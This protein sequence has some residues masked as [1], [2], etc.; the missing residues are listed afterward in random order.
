MKHKQ[1]NLRTKF[2]GFLINI[3]QKQYYQ[4]S[5][6][7]KLP[8]FTRTNPI[9]T[10]RISLKSEKQTN[11]AHLI[12]L[13]C[14]GLALLTSSKTETNRLLSAESLRDPR[15]IASGSFCE[16]YTLDLNI[17]GE[18]ALAVVVAPEARVPMVQ[19]VNV[20]GGLTRTLGQHRARGD[21]IINTSYEKFG[22]YL[23][24]KV[25]RGFCAN[26]NKENRTK[27]ERVWRP[28]WRDSP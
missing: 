27:I 19:P 7:H 15:R 12:R 20:S 16:F 8:Q 5:E 3:H 4:S 13:T 14:Q 22:D 9:K 25:S 21:R 2:P 17:N 1:N 11:K 24:G 28:I 10:M 26:A 6:N 18:K 23:C